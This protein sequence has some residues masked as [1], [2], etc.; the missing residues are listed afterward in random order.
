[1][2]IP[3]MI[4]SD[5]LKPIIFGGGKIALRKAQKLCNQGIQVTIIAP[6]IL[7]EFDRLMPEPIK[8]YETYSVGKMRAYNF[9]IA[10][11]N[12][13]KSNNK[14]CKEAEKRGKLNLNVSEGMNGSAYFPAN[15]SIGD[16]TIALATNGSSPAS[17][18]RILCELESSLMEKRWPERVEILREIRE[19]L[20]RK[21]IDPHMRQEIMRQVANLPLGELKVRRNQYASK[22]WNARK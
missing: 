21:R 22:D 10:A 2:W 15:R 16:I 14:I 6:E 12:D 7:K 20:K 9:V 8:I 19:M 5:V 1:M 13:D 18:Q 4:K 11:T 3:M 17:S